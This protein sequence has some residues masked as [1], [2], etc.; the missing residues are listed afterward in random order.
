[1]RTREAGAETIGTRGRKINEALKFGEKE[2]AAGHES[3][4]SD[5]VRAGE[6]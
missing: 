3:L 5:I 2:P 4:R 6:S 1:M